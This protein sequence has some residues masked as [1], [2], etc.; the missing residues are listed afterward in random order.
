MTW[1]SDEV[2]QQSVINWSREVSWRDLTVTVGVKSLP[3]RSA[4]KHY[5]LLITQKH[6]LFSIYSVLSTL[7]ALSL[8]FLTTLCKASIRIPSSHIKESSENI[9]TSRNFPLSS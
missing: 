9:K 1:E 2:Q 4:M 5:Y 3:F 8:L 7:P 6:D